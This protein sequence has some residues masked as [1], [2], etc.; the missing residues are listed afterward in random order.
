MNAGSEKP[1]EA[2]AEWTRHY[3]RIGRP[4]R[5]GRIRYRRQLS[6]GRLALILL[7]VAAVLVSVALA[8]L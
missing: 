2:L 5:A 7:A 6:P 3:E 4:R 1:V 8:K